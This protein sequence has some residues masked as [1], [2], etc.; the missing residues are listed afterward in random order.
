M[1]GSPSLVKT[2]YTKTKFKT[3]R[4]LDDFVKCCDPDTGYEYFMR[5]YFY[6]QHPTRGQ[7]L[8]DPYDFQLK[9]ID[10]YHTHRFSVSMMPRQTG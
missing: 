8:Y 1:S 5:N 9:L 4:D 6:I 2:P 7:L 10:N 3:Q